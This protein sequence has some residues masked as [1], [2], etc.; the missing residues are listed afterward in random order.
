MYV[1]LDR[2]LKIM[3]SR[4]QYLVFAAGKF[5]VFSARQS[6]QSLSA[7]LKIYSTY[8]MDIH[9]LMSILYSASTLH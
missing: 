7:S 1:Q 3:R 5:K 9:Q 2:L 6:E 4:D 8:C